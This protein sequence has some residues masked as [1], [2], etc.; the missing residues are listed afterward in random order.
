MADKIEKKEKEIKLTLKRDEEDNLVLSETGFPIYVDQDG[1]DRVYD[2][3]KLLK[4]KQAANNESAGR[5][6]RI[7][8]LENQ[9]NELQETY[10][11][12]D[13]D[14][15]RKAIE[16]LQNIDQQQL[17]DTGGVESLKREMREAFELDKKKIGEEWEKK[18]SESSLALDIKTRQIRDLLVRNAF[19]SSEFLREKTLLVPE[20]AYSH[21][22]NYFEV[23]EI[24]GVPTAV[25]KMDGDLIYSKRNPG[26]LADTEE[27]I[28][29][30]IDRLPFKERILR[31][32]VQAGSGI[33]NPDQGAS[34]QP[35]VLARVVYP[36][37]KK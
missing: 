15:A 20:M 31:G 18:V 22:G 30:I 16:K 5:R 25:G 13:V 3:E 28:E 8:E 23:Q 36:S 6:K 21:L 33:F 12:L 7:E 37:M 1:E 17:M 9:L 2:V 14:E 11:D 29:R 10:K 24:N 34:E 26:E 4:D 32:N 27:A 19:V 35:D